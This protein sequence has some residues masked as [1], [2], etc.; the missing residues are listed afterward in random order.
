[1]VRAKGSEGGGA[2]GG[3]VGCASCNR[4][5]PAVAQLRPAPWPSTV[6]RLLVHKHGEWVHGVVRDV[7]RRMSV[8]VCRLREGPFS[9]VPSQCN[10][11]CVESGGRVSRSC[12]SSHTHAHTHAHTRGKDRAG[13]KPRHNHGHAHTRL[14][15]STAREKKKKL[16]TTAR[17]T[18]ASRAIPPQ[19]YLAS[20]R[21]TA[22]RIVPVRFSPLLAQRVTVCHAP[23]HLLPPPLPTLNSVRELVVH[24]GRRTAYA[25]VGA[26]PANCS[27]YSQ[28][29]EYA[30]RHRA[31]LPW[32][33][34]Y[35]RH[36]APQK[37]RK[38]RP[39]APSLT[40]APQLL[41][42]SSRA[43]WPGVRQ[44]CR[45][46]RPAQGAD[47]PQRCPRPC[48]RGDRPQRAHTAASNQSTQM[49]TAPGE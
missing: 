11:T 13:H 21:A 29:F 17:H 4:L 47:G 41:T 24:V 36:A 44:A 30:P 42:T 18:H 7:R 23:Q 33:C 34:S 26:A 16:V 12:M 5:G 6:S 27:A 1:M 9:S 2:S 15:L 38:D 35:P 48:R 32:R 39:G 40:T 19:S 46:W 31:R 20:F 28:V 8:I 10:A 49:E 22:S 3:R 43:W 14:S 25:A 37:R 45:R